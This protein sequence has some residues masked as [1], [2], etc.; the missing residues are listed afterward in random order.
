MALC[1]PVLTEP[2]HRL[3]PGVKAAWDETVIG[4]Q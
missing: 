4:S 1:P 3:E 2:A